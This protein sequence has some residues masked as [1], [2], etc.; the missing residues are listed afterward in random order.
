[1]CKIYGLVSCFPGVLANG[2]CKF[3]NIR[4]ISEHIP[5]F[6]N[7]SFGKIFDVHGLLNIFLSL[8]VLFG[9]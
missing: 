4:G 9:S 6:F 1:L 8:F 3:I 7:D 5:S 2:R